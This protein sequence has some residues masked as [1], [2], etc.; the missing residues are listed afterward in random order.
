MINGYIPQNKRKKIL[1]LGD[2]LRMHSGVATMA[3]EIV[4]GTAN[5]YNWVVIGAAIDHPEAGQRL[6]LS[7]ATNKE[8]GNTD[9][10]Y[11]GVKNTTLSGSTT[12]A[13][14]RLTLLNIDACTFTGSHI[15]SIYANNTIANF[16]EA[17]SNNIIMGVNYGDYNIGD[18]KIILG[19]PGIL[20]NFDYQDFNLSSTDYSTILGSPNKNDYG[21]GPVMEVLSVITGHQYH[22]GA[23]Y[24][25]FDKLVG[26][27]G[28]SS[29]LDSSVN[30]LLLDWFSTAG[31][32][33][34]DLP[35]PTDYDGRVVVFKANGN[36]SATKIIRLDGVAFR[37]D[38]NFTYSINA[39]YMV[40]KIMAMDG[41]WWIID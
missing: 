22:Y 5:H 35:D 13:Y 33:D 31:T 25:G 40:V 19:W 9:S 15:D 23:Q 17:G 34:I 4:L 30:T 2:D 18:N 36:I 6:D 12:T 3:R 10:N 32:Y 8:T 20:R 28:G 39:A 21:N 41:Q 11:I 26:S 37:I 24:H 29:T 27:A 1:F 7:E 14:D 38:A 16:R